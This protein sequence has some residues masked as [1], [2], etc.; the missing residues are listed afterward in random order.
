MPGVE[1]QRFVFEGAVAQAQ[2]HDRLQAKDGKK[3]R[4]ADPGRTAARGVTLERLIGPFR[5]V[6][7]DWGRWHDRQNLGL[8][9]LYRGT[10]RGRNSFARMSPPGVSARWRPPRPQIGRAH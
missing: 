10:R 7:P 3:Y 4:A 6:S 1:V 9:P 5:Q 2:R 8:S